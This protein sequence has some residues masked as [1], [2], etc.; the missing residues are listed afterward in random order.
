M[1]VLP[2]LTFNSGMCGLTDIFEKLSMT[3]GP[4][5]IKSS[6][7]KDTKR[8]RNRSRKSSES[9]KKCRKKLRAIKKGYIDLDREKE[10][11]ESYQSGSY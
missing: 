4:Y 3:P 1:S 2:L 9:F 10:G 7:R 5:F 8:Y 6:S 11:G